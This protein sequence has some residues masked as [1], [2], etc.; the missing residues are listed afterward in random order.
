MEAGF[1]GHTTPEQDAA[2]RQLRKLL[3]GPSPAEIPELCALARSVEEYICG[4]DISVH[5]MVAMQEREAVGHVLLS[6]S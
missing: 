4:F 6:W 2:Q 1:P 5:K 3:H